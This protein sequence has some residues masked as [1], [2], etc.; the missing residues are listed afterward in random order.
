MPKVNVYLPEDLASAVRAAG[1]P[2]SPVCQR[3]LSEAVRRVS[4]ARPAIDA[5]RDPGRDP[6]LPIERLIQAG[7]RITARLAQSMHVAERV[8]G[9][10]S[11]LSSAHLL[12]G[13]LEQGDNLAVRV[14]RGLEVDLDELADELRRL[15]EDAHGGD[16][17]PPVELPGGAAH[18]SA[19]SIWVVMT[20]A[21]REALAVSLESAI[22][23][24]HNYVGC[25]HLLLGLAADPGEAAGR[26]LAGVAVDAAALRRAVNGA[27]AGYMH[28]SRTDLSA[29]MHRLD[30]LERRLDALA[31]SRDGGGRTAT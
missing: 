12:L 5:I 16:R 14:L 28:A 11:V 23:L 13:L 29:V 20:P 9:P 22:E 15:A 7:D 30:E 27:L 25:E 4:A 6:S 26:A 18:R 2:V 19:R 8:A 10:G 17:E 24:A 21:A 3:A 1:V 31:A